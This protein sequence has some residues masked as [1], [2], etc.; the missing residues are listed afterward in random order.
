MPLWLYSDLLW[1]LRGDPGACVSSG[2][3]LEGSLIS[4]STVPHCGDEAW[5]L[6]PH[7]GHA[8]KPHVATESLNSVHIAAIASYCLKHLQRTQR[9]ETS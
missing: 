5:V 3:P 7:C 1:A 2:Y 4:A 9:V 6:T 8:T